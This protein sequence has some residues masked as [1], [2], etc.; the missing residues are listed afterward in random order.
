MAGNFIFLFIGVL[1]VRLYGS[2]EPTINFETLVNKWS[3]L[4]RNFIDFCCRIADSNPRYMVTRYPWRCAL[5]YL[6]ASS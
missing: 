3:I 5:Q 6:Y 2:N 1:G 4:Y